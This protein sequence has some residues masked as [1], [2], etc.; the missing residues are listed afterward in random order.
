[1]RLR[2]TAFGEL[3]DRPLLAGKH[4]LAVALTRLGV[5]SDLGLLRDRAVD[6]AL[7]GHHLRAATLARIGDREPA[8]RAVTYNSEGTVVRAHTGERTYRATFA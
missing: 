4:Q 8:A 2:A 7:L 5:Q 3:S 1:M 6:V